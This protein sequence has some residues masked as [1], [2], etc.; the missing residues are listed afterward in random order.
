MIRVVSAAVVALALNGCDA[1]PKTP[2]DQFS[3]DLD[4][5]KAELD[6]GWFDAPEVE[7]KRRA[8]AWHSCTSAAVDAR[9]RRTAKG[10]QVAP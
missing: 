10:R 1:K 5:C 6:Q 3:S 4:A 8:V 2:W 7:R 9:D